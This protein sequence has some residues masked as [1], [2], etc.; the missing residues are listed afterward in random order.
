[1]A[2][3]EADAEAVPIPALAI[4]MIGVAESRDESDRNRYIPKLEIMN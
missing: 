4:K 1:L 3:E 2:I